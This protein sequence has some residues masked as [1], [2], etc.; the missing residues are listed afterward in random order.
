MFHACE[1]IKKSK[2][3]KWY[4]TH[5]RKNWLEQDWKKKQRKALDYD[6]EISSTRATI[7]NIYPPN[8]GACKYIKQI[9]TN[10]KGE[11][12]SN[13]AVGDFNTLLT[14]IDR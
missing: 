10:T 3:E 13:T 7:V 8:I 6:K 14:S 11:I 2:V 12:K 9:W 4:N 1:N 5:I